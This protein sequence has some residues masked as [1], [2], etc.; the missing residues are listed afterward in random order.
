M[1][2]IILFWLAAPAAIGIGLFLLESVPATFILFHGV[3][4]LLI[5]FADL[6]LFRGYRGKELS[7][8][9][10][11]HH[12]RQNLLQSLITGSCI[13][14]AVFLF[15]ALLQERIMNLSSVELLL[16]RWGVQ[17]GD[18]LWFVTVMVLLNSVVEEIYWRGFI[19]GRL[20]EKLSPG[21]TIA[22]S[23][24]FYASYHGL[25]T[26]ALFSPLY[27]V[28]CS[29]AVFLGGVYWGYMRLRRN[30]V[31]FSIVTHFMADLGIML[32]YLK[33]FV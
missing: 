9:L 3:V 19:F 10:G 31:W 20:R 29:I 5:P 24:A 4:C 13:C 22:L 8:F 21:M 12:F 7:D 2:A 30:T 18:T 23:S 25:T 27:A 16:A 6:V 14:A 26:G 17:P 32:I 11:L 1:T 33:Y 28:I 15:F